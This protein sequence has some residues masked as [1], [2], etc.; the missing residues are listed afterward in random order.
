MHPIRKAADE[1]NSLVTHI[2][3]W[4][5]GAGVMARKNYETSKDGVEVQFAANYLGHFLLTNLL[6]Q[7]IIK[8]KGTIVNITSMAYFIAEA[9][10]EDPNFEVCNSTTYLSVIH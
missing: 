4:V 8:A 2:D 3:I 10:T 1:I 5:N 7:K 9:D 6:L